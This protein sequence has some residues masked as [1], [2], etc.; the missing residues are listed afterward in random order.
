MPKG[1]NKGRESERKGRKETLNLKGSFRFI[2]IY[3]IVA[4]ELVASRNKNGAGLSSL[5]CV[6][7]H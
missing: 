4:R 3:T 1:R 5:N 7:K 2:N 6:H